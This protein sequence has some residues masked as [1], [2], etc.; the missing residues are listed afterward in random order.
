MAIFIDDTHN[1]TTQWY[2]GWYNRYFEML[3]VFNN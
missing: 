3:F 1:I 2:V